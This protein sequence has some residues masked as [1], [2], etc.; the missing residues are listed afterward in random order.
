[1]K[2]AVIMDVTFGVRRRSNIHNREQ[3]LVAEE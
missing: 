1:M 3:P 2:V